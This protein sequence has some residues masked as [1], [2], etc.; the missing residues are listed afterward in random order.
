MSIK[1]EYPEIIK[2]RIKDDGLDDTP[3][4]WETSPTIKCEIE[5]F[6]R[7]LQ[8]TIDFLDNDCTAEQ[9]SW[10]A[11]VFEEISA[12]LQSWDFVDALRRVAEKYPEYSKKYHLSDT[13]AIAEAQ[14][15]DSIYQQRY[16]ISEGGERNEYKG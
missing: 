13:I 15:E 6:T 5:L 16:P 3:D 9:L 4:Y 11:E 2:Q 8:E 12:K 14:L 10:M 7:N 1:D